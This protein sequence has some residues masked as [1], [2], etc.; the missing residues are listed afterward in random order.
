MLEEGW[1]GG[2]GIDDE[3]CGTEGRRTNPPELVSVYE[4]RT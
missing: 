2:D 1:Q 4:P 3:I